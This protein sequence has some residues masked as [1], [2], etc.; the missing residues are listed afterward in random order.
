MRIRIVAHTIAVLATLAVADA[1]A[2]PA[3]SYLTP[4]SGPTAYFAVKGSHGYTVEYVAGDGFS[5][6]SVSDHNSKSGLDATT[7][8]WEFSGEAGAERTHLDLARFGGATVRFRQT[9]KVRRDP[10]PGNCEGGPTVT[11]RGVFV[12]RIRFHGEGGYTEVD[13]RRARGSLEYTPQRTCKAPAKRH[14]KPRKR[15]HKQRRGP[16]ATTFA[17]T[18][19]S[20]GLSFS[21]VNSTTEPASTLYLATVLSRRD[22]IA[23]SRHATAFGDKD[24]FSFDRGLN[25]ATIS[26]PAPFSGSATFTRIDDSASRWEGSL[27]VSFPGLAD[28][29]LTGRDFGWGL[30]SKRERQSGVAVFSFGSAGAGHSRLLRAT[31]P[32]RQLA[33]WSGSPGRGG[34]GR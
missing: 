33:A 27:T 13:A 29:P 23:I 22:G 30:T 7:D 11:R 1:T 32:G 5:T 6:I 26:P 16:L 2:A 9:G 3:A 10:A 25:N 34:T 4:A 8:Y 17:A 19:G 15:G 28:V 14:R 12:G 31:A 18:N 20:S 21:A 24:S